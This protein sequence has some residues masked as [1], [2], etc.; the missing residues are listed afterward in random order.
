MIETPTEELSTKETPEKSIDPTKPNIAS[1]ME[2]EAKEEKT[3]SGE[4]EKPKS[5]DVGK[6]SLK[7]DPTLEF[8]NKMVAKDT[9]SVLGRTGLKVC[10]ITLG[11]M[12][13]GEIDDSFGS[14]PGQLN[15]A[16]AHKILDKYVELGGNCIDTANFFPWF[17][18]KAG[19]SERIIGNWLKKLDLLFFYFRNVSRHFLR[20]LRILVIC[21]TFSMIFR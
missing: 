10:R 4:V 6:T 3:R 9:H 1:S 15:E 21:S 20:Y 17:G 11:S 13:F 14:R 7:K 16:E 19:E 8:F 2:Q 18:A 5:T 12:N